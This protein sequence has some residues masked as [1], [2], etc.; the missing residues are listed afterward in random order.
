MLLRRSSH[1]LLWS[2]SQNPAECGA[3]VQADWAEFDLMCKQRRN[4]K[5]AVKKM[6]PEYISR[7]L[8]NHL[9]YNL[10]VD[11]PMFRDMKVA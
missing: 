7:P 9:H 10:L 11:V 3:G 1:V 8:A 5:K 4:A 6:V 2:S